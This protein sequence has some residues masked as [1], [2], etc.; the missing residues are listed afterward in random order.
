[1]S[2]YLEVMLIVKHLMLMAVKVTMVAKT[3]KL[4]VDKLL[5][6]DDLPNF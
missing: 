5:I 6:D 1:M 2:G 3:M 4:M